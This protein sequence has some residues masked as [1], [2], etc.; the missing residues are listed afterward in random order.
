MDEQEQRWEDESPAPQP[1]S[2]EVED[3]LVV[4]EPSSASRLSPY[5][6]SA[7]VISTL[8][9]WL[10]PQA[11]F[12]PVDF[13]EWRAVLYGVLPQVL[14]AVGAVGA[15]LWMASHA[16]KEILLADGHLGGVGFYRSARVVVIVTLAVLVS[17]IGLRLIGGDP[18]ASNVEFVDEPP[19]EGELIPPLPAQPASP[20]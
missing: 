12:P 4:D 19:V 13:V 9:L 2:D 7:F 20:P 15:A 18:F 14:P 16:A 11:W 8:G 10:S 3:I 6:I 17:G 5:A 1:Q